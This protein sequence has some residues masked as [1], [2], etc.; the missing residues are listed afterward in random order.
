MYKRILV[1]TDGSPTSDKAMLEALALAKQ[2]TSQMLLLHVVDEAP[3]FGTSG[4]SFS[5]QQYTKAV[6][7]AGHKVLSEAKAKVE[8]QSVQVETK[9]IALDPFSPSQRIFDLIDAEA[10]NWPADLIV[11]GTHGRRGFRR[12]LLGSVAEGL[13]RIAEKPVLVIRCSPVTGIGSWSDTEN[14][15]SS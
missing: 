6:H 4:S 9:C 7:K 8:Q 12:F 13:L 10:N 5:P 14:S 3:P 11:I 15:R 1:A 2:L